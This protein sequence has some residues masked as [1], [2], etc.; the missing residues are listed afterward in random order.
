M[1]ALLYRGVRYIK[2]GDD[3][4]ELYDVEQDPG[5]RRNLALLPDRRSTIAEYRSILRAVSANGRVSAV[6]REGQ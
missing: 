1:K 5:E 3:S 2:N 4:E 6:P